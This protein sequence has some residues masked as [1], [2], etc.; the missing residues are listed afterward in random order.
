MPSDL[1]AERILRFINARGYKPRRLGELAEAMGIGEA[2]QGD[3]RAACKALMKTGRVVLGSENALMLS[4]P[5]GKVVGTFRG[6]PRG[7]GFVI[8]DT[9]NAHGDLYVPPDKTGGALTGDT[10]AARV[11]KR[12]KRGGHMR[13]EARVT[14]IVQR[15]QSRFVGELRRELGRWFVVPDGNTL[16]VPITVGDPG[17][18]GARPGDQVVIEIIQYP[19]AAREAKGVI[20]KVLGKRG[21]PGVDAASIIEQYGLP[22]DFD[23][24]VAKEA[25]TAASAYDPRRAAAGEREDLRGLTVITID[26]AD[27]RDFDDAISLTKRRGG[28]VELGVHIADVAHFVPEGGAI[29]STAR[30]RSNSVYLPG[31]VIPMLPE[32][33]SNGVCSLQERQT[34]LT[35]S[36]FIT[37]DRQGCVKGARVANTVIR[38]TKRLTY[39]QATAVIEGRSGRLSAK[40]VALMK[41]MESLARAIR[42]RRLQEGMFELDL[43]DIEMVY[44]DDGQV[45]DVAPEDTSFSHKIIEMFMVEANEAVS[46]L[47]TAEGLPHLR[48]IH[49]RP[50]DLSLSNLRRF[51]SAVGHALPAGADRFAVQALL[52]EVRGTDEAFAV[53]LAVLRSMQQ[54]EYAPKRAGHYALASEDYCH[55]TSPIRRYPDLAVHRLLDAYL[56][57][58]LSE[59]GGRA[60]CPSEVEL[61]ELGSK[62]TTNEQ[63]AEAAER[64]LKLVLVLRLLDKRIGDAMNGIVTG[65]ANV[66][67][68]VQLERYLVDGLLPFELLPDDWWEVDPTHGCVVGQRSGHRIKVGDRLKVSIN[69]VHLSTRRLDLALAQRLD[70]RS[71]PTKRPGAQRR[72]KTPPQRGRRAGQRGPSRSAQRDTRTPRR[73]TGKPRRSKRRRS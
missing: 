8:P 13:Y 1:F 28:A 14:A 25:H 52:D 72:A 20:V 45:V 70:G 32:V 69:Q 47:L 4:G 71:A 27:A 26:P 51:L 61:R 34:R 2:E 66:G 58:A 18:K 36:V 60:R 62:C 21:E 17:A 65:V 68:F 42:T 59:S 73:P 23:E 24:A 37:Y 22:G 41:D 44:D 29:D 57:G 3:F 30:E 16:H 39:E 6:N 11:V 10:V 31:L 54:A 12:G 7:F 15:G 67:V 9:P 43:P 48:R 5:P 64:E 56:K 63:R 40:V 38:S 49:E 53:H 19:G 46:R 33:L 50:R 55:F 35:K